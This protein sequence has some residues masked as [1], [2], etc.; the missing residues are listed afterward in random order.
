[1]VSYLGPAFAAMM[2]G[3]V[4]IEEIFTLPGIGGHF[5]R[6]ALARDYNLVLGVIIL[7][8]TLLVVLNLVVDIL[9]TY[10]D[11]RVTYD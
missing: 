4:V 11:P 9:Y 3:S 5:V 1:V 7:Y 2:T 10:L 8:S 6:A